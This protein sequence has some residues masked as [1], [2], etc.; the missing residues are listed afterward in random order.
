MTTGTWWPGWGGAVLSQPNHKLYSVMVQMCWQLKLRACENMQVQWCRKDVRQLHH[1]D[2]E[3]SLV[4]PTPSRRR[5][6][7]SSAG[8]SHDCF[9]DW[10]VGQPELLRLFQ[11]TLL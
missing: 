2:W 10:F 7:S 11:Q 4:V 5:V 3:A 8:R 9:H 6:V 1:F